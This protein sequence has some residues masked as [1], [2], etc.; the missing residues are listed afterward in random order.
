M[1]KKKL[2]VLMLAVLSGCRSSQAPKKQKRENKMSAVTVGMQAPDFTLPDETGTERTL[3]AFRGQKVAL[4]FYPKDDTPGCTAQACNMR[5]EY[6]SLRDANIQILGVSYDS[7][8]S[9]QK[10]K[11]K[12]HL[13][14]PLL[15]DSTK[16]VAKQY[17]V[18][19]FLGV[20]PQRVTF[21][22]DEQ[23]VVVAVIDKVEVGRHTDQVLQGFGVS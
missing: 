13:T 3:S 4:Y 16:Q 2:L 14:F 1:M 12:Y 5:D 17:G 20:V 21:L 11:E 15:S 6:A 8:A 23:G 9:H 18:T 19:G 22:I 10:F 7:P